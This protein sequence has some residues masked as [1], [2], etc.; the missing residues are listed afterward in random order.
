M[1][2]CGNA[3]ARKFKDKAEA[4]PRQGQGNGGKKTLRGDSPHASTEK[5][6]KRTPQPSDLGALLRQGQEVI[7][8]KPF[9]RSKRKIGTACGEKRIR[10]NFGTKKKATKKPGYA[11]R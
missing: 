8:R 10:S 7:K 1:P 9:S 3:H 4:L 2:N 6:K 11:Y 5:E